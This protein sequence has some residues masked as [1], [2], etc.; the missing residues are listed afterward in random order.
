MK[1][2]A[3]VAGEKSGDYLGAEIVKAI[4]VKH[5]DAQFC[6]LAGPLMQEAGV[7]SLAE[8]D[9]IS[10]MGFDGLWSSL[11]EILAIRKKLYTHFL[12]WQPDVFVGIDVPDFNLGLEIKL[13]KSGIPIAHC[14]SPTVWAWR[15]KR[16]HKIKRAINVM[17]ALFPFEADYY[18]S[19]QAPVRCIGHP[20]AK[21]VRE[22]A[23]SSE[24]NQ[25]AP[26]TKP[27]RIA[28]LPGS[29]MSEVSRLAGVMFAA[30]KQLQQSHPQVEF[31]VPAANRSLHAY[32]AELP[33]YDD[34]VVS[35]VDG[36]SRD[37]LASSDIAILASGTAALEAAL[38]AKP[39]VVLYKVSKFTAW[40]AGRTMQ[41]DHYS[42]PNHLTSPPAVREFVQEEANPENIVSE[43]TRLI[44]D[45]A[46][47]ATM[48][49]ALAAIAPTLDLE[50]GSLVCDAL[51]QLVNDKHAFE[52]QH[53]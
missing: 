7:E 29:R 21:Q 26:K 51:E 46:Y 45:A 11:R 22:W 4:K 30:A 18:R 38:F 35:I 15:G 37:V 47:Y 16:I 20:L 49:T 32:M 13:K 19:H 9:K 44:D 52:L 24:F 48:H 36:F 10:I 6:G 39:M 50:T 40:Y 1:R 14:V 42:M 3:I 23:L 12:K 33:E 34:S 25:L 27:I 43:V 5:P 8:M 41:V 17:L 2:I 53:D 28:I 31:V